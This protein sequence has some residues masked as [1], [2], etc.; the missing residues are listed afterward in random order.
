MQ[1]QNLLFFLIDKLLLLLSRRAGGDHLALGL[2]ILEKYF[3]NQ[4]ERMY[5]VCLEYMNRKQWFFRFIAGKY[6]GRFYVREP[7]AVKNYLEKLALD[8]EWQVR[9]GA[10]WG[11]SSLWERQD[12]GNPQEEHGSA[13]EDDRIIAKRPQPVEDCISACYTHWL[14]DSREHL[15]ATAALSLVP[16]IKKGD[17]GLLP[18]LISLLDRLMQ[19]DSPK[20]RGLVGPQLI[21]KA[22]A[23]T[24]PATAKECLQRWLAIPLPVTQWQIARAVCGSL[25]IVFPGE[26]MQI[27]HNLQCPEHPLVQGGLVHALKRLSNSANPDL[28]LAAGKY[29]EELG[30]SKDKAWL[31]VTDKDN[32][33]DGQERDYDAL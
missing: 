29:A 11:M 4:P 25:S 22:L 18:V 26:V 16:V 10:A 8:P 3:A 30:F 12:S 14:G 7:A 31:K 21:G 20:V 19:D 6:L 27:L 13:T 23:E 32:S 15:R 9:E 1:M 33:P 24:F 28:A 5:T 17:P 2:Q